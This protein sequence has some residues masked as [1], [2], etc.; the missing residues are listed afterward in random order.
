MKMRGHLQNVQQDWQTKRI[1]ATFELTE[2]NPGDLAKLREEDLDIEAKKH[3]ERR[4]NN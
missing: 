1:I 4:R 2:V 3:S